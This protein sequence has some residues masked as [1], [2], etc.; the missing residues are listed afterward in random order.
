MRSNGSHLYGPRVGLVDS[1]R[2]RR[3]AAAA[4]KRAPQRSGRLAVKSSC[5]AT[6]IRRRCTATPDRTAVLLQFCV[7]A[8]YVDGYAYATFSS[9]SAASQNYNLRRRTH[10]RLYHLFLR[11]AL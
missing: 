1:S 2:G 6:D 3:L 10:D 11:D 8:L 9:Q 7:L 5:L 4:Q